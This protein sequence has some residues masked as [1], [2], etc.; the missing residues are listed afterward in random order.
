MRADRLV[1]T[2]L[3]LQTRGRVTARELADELEV[4]EKTARRDL[5]ALSMA[6]LPVYAQAGRGGGWQL[7]GGGRTDLSGLT[8][9]EARAL[10]LAAGTAPT[11]GSDPTSALR[12]LVRALPEPFRAEAELAAQAVI[13]DPT[14]WGSSDPPPPPEHLEVLQRAVV[15]RRRVL[16]D[17]VDRT[18]TPSERVVEPLGLVS[19]G[20]VWYVVASTDRGM[21]TF[22]VGRIRRADL[23]DTTFERPA[24]FD[25]AAAW[26]TVVDNVG[27]SRIR[28]RATVRLDASYVGWLR[29]QFGADMML[30]ELDVPAADGRETVLVGGPSAF[31]IAQHLAG[32]GRLV[33]VVEPLEVRHHL[34]RIARELL[35][36]YA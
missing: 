14:T 20:T 34:T 5:E 15:E 31:V 23:L 19:K 3:L 28:V 32:W 22:R 11:T 2:L 29:S 6:G 21:R 35:D 33:E 9:D 7:L 12:K 18:R 4:S 17:Y 10:F 30:A 13:V 8:V 27:E 1:A 25:L 24:D 16:L 36:T 26:Q